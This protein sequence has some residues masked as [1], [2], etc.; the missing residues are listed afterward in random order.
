MVEYLLLLRFFFIFFAFFLWEVDK[1][2]MLLLFFYMSA[3]ST[4]LALSKSRSYY[5]EEGA[6]THRT[7]LSRMVYVVNVSHV[8]DEDYFPQNL[9]G[10][11]IRGGVVGT[12]LRASAPF[13]CSIC[14]GLGTSS[15]IIIH[16][17]HQR[18]WG[19]SYGYGWINGCMD[20]GGGDED[21][22]FVVG[23]NWWRSCIT[24]LLLLH[25]Y[26][27]LLLFLLIR[28]RRPSKVQHTHVSNS[29]CKGFK[30]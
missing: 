28:S 30:F 23:G 1:R 2:W 22:D 25:R 24:S 29:L 8:S 11:L 18:V 4:W 15:I 7:H 16:R 26:I 6:S 3:C 17:R 14:L 13:R 20:D 5:V 21:E 9:I 19:A 10:I 27:L 12:T